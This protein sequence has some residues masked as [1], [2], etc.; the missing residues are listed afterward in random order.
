[1][2]NKS[3][4]WSQKTKSEFRNMQAKAYQS[5]GAAKVE[6]QHNAGKLTARERI[7]LLF[8]KGTF[9]EF[10][11]L[12][13]SRQNDLIIKKQ[14]YLGDGV[15]TGYGEIN[16]KLSFAA[17]QDAAV[18]GGAGGEEHIN[19]VVRCLKR[20]IEAQAPFISL[21]ESGGAR[22]E[23]G[24]DSLAAYSNLF[25]LNTE[26]SGYI[27]QIAAI[28]GNCAGGSSYS[29]V[30]HDF[31]FMVKSSQMYITGPQVIE[32]LT[33]EK[34]T[35]EELGGADIHSKKSGQAHFTYNSDE[36]CIEG[37]RRLLSYLPQNCHAHAARNPF[38]SIDNCHGL[39]ELV[40]ENKRIPYDIKEVVK[41]IF[42]EKSFMEVSENFAPNICIGFAR[43]EGET[44][45]L[46]AN[47]PNVLGGTLDCDAADK[48]ARFV[49]FC[50][51]FN[52]P[53]ITLVDVP[54]FMPGKVQ[55]E[56]G[57]LRHGSKLLYAFS[58][59]TVP[60]ITLILR[61]AYGGAYCAM[62]SK[63]LKG[64]MVFAWPVCEIAVM[65]ADGAVSVIFK[66]QIENAENPVA[67]KEKLVGQYNELYL[68]PYF[69]ASRA[70]VDEI[71]APEDTRKKF[72][73]ALKMLREKNVTRLDKK[74]GNI[75]L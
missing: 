61:K 69:A 73:A 16:G 13:M 42:D 20:A 35:M 21:N 33:G 32:S 26:A 10:N 68:N 65:G 15:I 11:L 45:G 38:Q 37:I 72:I 29:P 4:L 5:G 28:M 56:K 6:K 58:E 54:A 3:A 57:I 19:K 9:Q 17:S 30:L 46:V 74:H 31:V 55:E 34:V 14:H 22:I 71:I 27:P 24:I 70:L 41:L 53:I 52:I 7:E 2:M 44:V 63:N 49:R 47:Q 18:S 67:E 60:K 23:E 48:G 40:P 1:M 36:E 25:Y 64:D 62:S 39:E 75:P 59:A 66:K 8:D 12:S 43:L 51:C 50:D